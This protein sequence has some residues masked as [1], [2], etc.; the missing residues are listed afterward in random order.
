MKKSIVFLFCLVLFSSVLLNGQVSKGWNYQ[1]VIRNS[2][3]PIANTGLEVRFTILK[4]SITGIPVYSEIHINSITNNFGLLT[5]PLGKGQQPQGQFDTIN[6]RSD[7]Y[8]LKVEMDLAGTPGGY[9]DFGTEEIFFQP[10]VDSEALWLK[11]ADND[12]Y[13]LNGRVGIGTPSPAES[14][15]VVGGTRLTG[16]GHYKLDIYATSAT[17]DN[18]IR[19]FDN[20]GNGMWNINLGDRSDGDRFMIDKPN[21]G[22]VDFYIDNNSITHVR[23]LQIHGGCDIKED[24]NSIEDLEPG[25]IVVIDEKNPGNIRRTNQEY[26]KKVAGI[27]SGANGINSGLSLSQNDVL[28]GKYP[29][30]MLGRVYVKVTGKIEI[31]D[32]L[33]TSSKPGFAMAV[34]DYS[35]AH[36]CV[37]GKAMTANEKEEG[38][39]LV[40]VN[41]Q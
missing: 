3:G 22:C 12:V 24:L 35:T 6:W 17:D 20:S 1:A 27:I 31:G 21:N 9:L 41:L 7:R 14:L 26:D 25:D 28:E 10:Q 11:N 33:T 38:L 8:F 29:L 15:E 23:S 18:I 4:S 13:R 19:S 32:M 40:L 36:G 39:V 2:I 30:A 5:L 16:G 37:I 34:K